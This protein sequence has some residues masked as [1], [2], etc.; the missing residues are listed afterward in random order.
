MVWDWESFENVSRIPSK[1]FDWIYKLI[2]YYLTYLIFL[3]Y[4]K[5]IRKHQSRLAWH[6]IIRKLLMQYIVQILEFI[7]LMMD[8]FITTWPNWNRTILKN[9]ILNL[10]VILYKN[11][12]TTH[13]KLFI[14]KTADLHIEIA[15][16]ELINLTR[17]L[18]FKLLKIVNIHNRVLIRSYISRSPIQHAVYTQSIRRETVRVSTYIVRLRLRT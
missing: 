18:L 16:G 13:E 7:N 15:V 2:N 3:N 1:D 9:P 4:Y 12:R 17:R 5:N 6:R 8:S 11:Y 14:S 10:L